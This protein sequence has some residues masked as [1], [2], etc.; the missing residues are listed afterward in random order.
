MMQFAKLF[1]ISH[2]LEVSRWFGKIA[3]LASKDLS[4]NRLLDWKKGQYI[5]DDNSILMFQWAMLGSIAAKLFYP[6]FAK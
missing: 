3:A 6:A 2:I 1:L 4:Q 5:N